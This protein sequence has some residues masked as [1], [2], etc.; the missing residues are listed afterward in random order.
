M[1]FLKFSSSVP[2]IVTCLLLYWAHR[3]NPIINCEINSSPA[4]K[5]PLS[6][7]RSFLAG[8]S[9]W[10]VIC[11]EPEILNN[12]LTR[13]PAFSF[14]TRHHGYVVSPISTVF[15]SFFNLQVLEPYVKPMGLGWPFDVNYYQGRGHNR[16]LSQVGAFQPSSLPPRWESPLSLLDHL[17]TFTP[18][19]S[20]PLS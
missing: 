13:G 12:I 6:F 10:H 3:Q 15:A 2:I 1:F 4:E 9:L 14:C 19:H 20:S 7:Y 8:L 11:D 5:D 16:F 18:T 17:V